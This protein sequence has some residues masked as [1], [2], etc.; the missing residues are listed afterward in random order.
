MY[1]HGLIEGRSLAEL[2]DAIE[3]DVSRYPAIDVAS[4]SRRVRLAVH[5]MDG[6]EWQ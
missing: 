5:A 4:F 3:P 1:Q 6:G 2:F